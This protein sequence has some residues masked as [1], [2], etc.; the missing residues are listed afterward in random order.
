MYRYSHLGLQFPSL[1]KRLL[2]ISP[3]AYLRSLTVLV[4][5]DTLLQPIYHERYT[6]MLYPSSLWNLFHPSDSKR[7]SRNM[8]AYDPPLNRVENNILREKRYNLQKKSNTSTITTV[9]RLKEEGYL[10]K[11]T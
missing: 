11:L 2:I 5:V 4:L 9:S 10:S 6:N 3:R 7:S 8:R 1:S